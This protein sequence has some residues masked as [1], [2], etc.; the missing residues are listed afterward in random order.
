MPPGIHNRRRDNWRILL[1]IADVAGGVWPEQAR[2]ACLGGLETDE[3]GSI[4]AILLADIKAVFQ[5][6]RV[7]RMASKDLAKRLGEIEG[8][9]WDDAG[10]SANS[11]A[12]L[13]KGHKIKPKTIRV[14]TKCLKGYHLDQ[15]K[16][17]FDRYL[18]QPLPDS[19]LKP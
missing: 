19:P 16:D 11:I 13:L 2:G 1:A 8:H 3:E 18:V 14:G 17:V 12:K 4:T 6:A 15:F 9:P 10:L 5:T 7:S